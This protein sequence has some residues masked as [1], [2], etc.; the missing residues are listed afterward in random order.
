MTLL[1]LNLMILSQFQH[2]EIMVMDILLYIAQSWISSLQSDTGFLLNLNILLQFI[3]LIN[4][5]PPI[6]INLLMVMMYHSSLCQEDIHSKPQDNLS[7]IML[8]SKTQINNLEFQYLILP[9]DKNSYYFKLIMI[10][11]SLFKFKVSNSTHKI[12]N[13]EL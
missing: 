13:S 10:K 5:T 1:F 8:F 3:L 7:G 4:L 11:K 12:S 2:T 6:K 9:K